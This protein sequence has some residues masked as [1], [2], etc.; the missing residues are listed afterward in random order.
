M[1]LQ[2]PEWAG[3]PVMALGDSHVI[4]E[5]VGP[6][7]AWPALAR[8]VLRARGWPLGRLHVLARTGWTTG[9]LL[10]ALAALH[11][12]ERFALCF[13]QVGVNDQV[14]GIP[15]ER[16]AAHLAQVLALAV[17]AV[18]GATAR[19]TCLS[20][21]NYRRTPAGRRMPHAASLQPWQDAAR[22]VALDHAVRWVD[23]NEGDD[24]LLETEAVASDG[25]HPSAALHARWALRAVAALMPG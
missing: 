11:P 19:V 7:L 24:G 18:A 1:S 15:P 14:R 13:V 2:S 8:H 20:L 22:K 3:L 16:M 17:A 9:D 6:G 25:L 10:A 4:G 12:D 5:A 21:P 23:V